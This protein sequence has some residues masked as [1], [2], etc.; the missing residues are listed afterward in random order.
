ME[1]KALGALLGPE[2]LPCLPCMAWRRKL[3]ED[4]KRRGLEL[5]ALHPFNKP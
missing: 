1:S 2:A 5:E 3:G 4:G